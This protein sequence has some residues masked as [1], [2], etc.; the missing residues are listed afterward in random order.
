MRSPAQRC[1]T[2]CRSFVR[3]DLCVL[4]GGRR[5]SQHRH[6]RGVSAAGDEARARVIL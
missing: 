2:L 4:A 3:K 6:V 1:G 5:S